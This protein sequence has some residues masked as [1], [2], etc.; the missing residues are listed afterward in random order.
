MIES[1]QVPG[2]EGVIEECIKTLEEQWSKLIDKSAEKA[3]KLKEA[4]QEQ[5]FN[6]GIKGKE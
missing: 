1:Q 2:Q 4:N 3:Q 5:Q 6:E